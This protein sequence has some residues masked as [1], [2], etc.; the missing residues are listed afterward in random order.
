[1][2]EKPAVSPACEGAD[3]RHEVGKIGQRH[4][5]WKPECGFGLDVG[6]ATLVPNARPRGHADREPDE[7][8]SKHRHQTDLLSGWVKASALSAGHAVAR[9]STNL[10]ESG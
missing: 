8:V 9:H 5:C 1:M 3:L 2:T 4:R 10:A 6:S 7:G